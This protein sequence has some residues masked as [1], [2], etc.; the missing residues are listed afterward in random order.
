M[1]EKEKAMLGLP[2]RQGDPD[3]AQA[4]TRA[5][6]LCFELNHTRP[7]D[8]EECS[9]ILRSL[10]GEIRGG[11]KINPPFYCD[12]GTY[13]TLG[14][15]FFANYNLT[16]LDGGKV[17]FGTD[18]KIGPNCSFITVNHSMDPQQ[19][20]EGVQ[21][22]LPITVGNN[23]WF[24]ANVTVLPGVT[25]GD[26]S[27]IAAGSVVSRDIPANVF[28]AGTPCRVKRVLCEDDRWKLTE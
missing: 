24:G 14:E 28:A 20:K 7:S 9:R 18:V 15:R 12:Y 8:A 4:R 19:R 26:N 23:V 13:I 5:K 6:D 11:F 22:F 1:T 17:T 27:V 2:F 25:I 3:L 10:I 16:I 21:V